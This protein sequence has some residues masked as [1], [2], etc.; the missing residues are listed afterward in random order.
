MYTP[1]KPTPTNEA[2]GEE[3]YQGDTGEKINCAGFE[4]VAGLR[5]GTHWYRGGE[6]CKMGRFPAYPPYSARYIQYMES[7]G[8]M[9]MRAQRSMHFWR[10]MKYPTPAADNPWSE[11][12]G[13]NEDASPTV[14]RT[15]MQD[16]IACESGV[17]GRNG[18]GKNHLNVKA[19]LAICS[20]TDTRAKLE[21]SWA[22]LWT[23]WMEITVARRS[24]NENR[25]TEK[26]H[27]AARDEEDMSA[28]H[29]A[30][31]GLRWWSSA[32]ECRLT[33][34][35]KSDHDVATKSTS[36]AAMK[37]QPEVQRTWPETSLPVGSHDGLKQ[38]VG[39]LPV[40]ELDVQ[41]VKIRVTDKVIG[42]HPD[43]ADYTA[44]VIS[45]TG[46][47]SAEK[48]ISCAA[49]FRS[50]FRNLMQTAMK[51]LET[52]QEFS[53]YDSAAY[54]AKIGI[55]L[56]EIMRPSA[57][58]V[59]KANGCALKARHRA[60]AAKRGPTVTAPVRIAVAA[61]SMRQP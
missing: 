6:T 37:Q 58:E 33:G 51:T 3:D 15:N 42:V 16:H 53:V 56:G 32:E 38:K 27:S 57:A 18:E 26:E 13:M 31:L 30:R 35:N 60:M 8:Q 9:R 34:V 24:K 14:A 54:L 47:V 45:E 20:V 59:E 5:K 11:M 2:L 25:S 46:H 29:L 39:A 10:V 52:S 17:M 28:T 21:G 55:A 50:G 22:V 49:Y 44:A 7:S 4:S 41:A 61:A 1:N 40:A 12:V 48:A 36:E 43:I 19:F 23:R